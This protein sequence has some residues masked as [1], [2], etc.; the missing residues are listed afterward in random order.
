MCSRPGIIP[1]ISRDLTQDRILCATCFYDTFSRYSYSYLQQSTTGDETLST[2]EAF[3]REA[4]LNRN[5]IRHYRTD[6]GRFAEKSFR[7]HVDKCVQTIDFCGVNAHRMNGLIKRRIRTLS[8]GLRPILL[9]IMRMW[10]EIIGTLLWSFALKAYENTLNAYDLDSDL[11]SP[12][13]KFAKS[14]TLPLVENKHT[15]GCPVYVPTNDLQI[16]GTQIPKWDPRV[17]L[18]IYLGHSPCH[19]G[20]TTLVMNPRTLHFSPQFYVVCD[21]D[22]TTVPAMRSVDIPGN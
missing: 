15:F 8:S 12:A 6:N 21:D 7:D 5:V 4:H 18:G 22:F 17:R 13:I 20:Y 9:H 16:A 19:A 3:E 1:K 11:K 10:P 2:K 14:E